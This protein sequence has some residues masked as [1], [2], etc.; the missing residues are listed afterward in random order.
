MMS[1]QMERVREIV[2]E[3]S[4]KLLATDKRFSYTVQMATDDGSFF[5]WDSAFAEEHFVDGRYWY[6]VCT[7][8]HGDHIYD[9]DDV[10]WIRVYGERKGLQFVDNGRDES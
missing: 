9:V 1:K 7:E 5:T 3:R 10:L 2:A 6:V 8:H 4:A